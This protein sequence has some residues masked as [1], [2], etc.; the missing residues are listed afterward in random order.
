MTKTKASRGRPS[1]ATSSTEKMQRT[2]RSHFKHQR[3]RGSHDWDVIFEILDAGLV[4]HVGFCAADQMFVIPM[5]YGRD[6][7]N[8]FLHGS[9][10]SRLLRELECGIQVCVTVTLIDGLVLS[11]S[12]F[13][14]S[15]NY[16]SVVAF[17]QAQI[18]VNRKEKLSALRLISEHLIAGR[19]PEV[20]APSVKQLNATT[21]LNFSIDEASA[22][23]RRGPPQDEKRDLKHP[24]WAGV[25]PLELKALPPIPDDNLYEGTPIPAYVLEYIARRRAA[26]IE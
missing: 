3:A 16:R 24:V 17:G 19:W 25:L 7:R 20:R 8:L 13:D 9:V 4:A 11:R 1:R 23:V 2:E 12:A 14:H 26:D 21:V 5:T 10:A 15:M 6:G 18:V 22:K